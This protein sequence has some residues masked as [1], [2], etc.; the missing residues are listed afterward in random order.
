MKQEI[1]TQEEQAARQVVYEATEGDIRL[2]LQAMIKEY[3]VCT[4]LS[5]KDALT[6]RLPNGQTFRIRV[7]DVTGN[8]AD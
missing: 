4:C 2:Q 8:V 6:M 5:Q 1:L 3:F 7:E